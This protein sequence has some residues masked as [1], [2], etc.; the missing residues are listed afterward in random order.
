M[1]TSYE[2]VCPSGG[3][4]PEEVTW[5]GL[6]SV[7]WAGQLLNMLFIKVPNHWACFVGTGT[8]MVDEGFLAT[9][10][11]TLISHLLDIFG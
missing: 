6:Q 2:R 7:R 3:E 1:K 5:A 4:Q 8:A 11:W 10:H 9:G